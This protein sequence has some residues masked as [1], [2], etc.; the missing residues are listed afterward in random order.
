M[1]CS[2]LTTLPDE[3]A[4]QF[5][6]RTLHNIHIYCAQPLS[7]FSTRVPSHR[8]ILLIVSELPATDLARTY[9]TSKHLSSAASITAAQRMIELGATPARI[10]AF[11]RLAAH[12]ALVAAVGPKPTNRRWSSEWNALA[13]EEFTL[14]GFGSSST[15]T[16]FDESQVLALEAALAQPRA[17]SVRAL[18]WASGWPAEGGAG[19]V[20][21]LGFCGRAALSRALSANDPCYVASTHLI[22]HALQ[23]RAAILAPSMPAPHAYRNLNGTGGLSAD[24]A[25]CWAALPTYEEWEEDSTPRNLHTSAL[26][27]A[28]TAEASFVAN[29]ETAEGYAVLSWAPTAA[30]GAQL[31]HQLQTDSP[32]VCFRSRAPDGKGYHSLIHTGGTSYCVPPMA[33][34]VLESVEKAGAWEAPNGK[35]VNQT[36][37]TVGVTFL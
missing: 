25:N 34:L 35:R 29:E 33:T 24:D 36:L 20:A 27:L 5:T 10:N 16:L 32:V 2:L 12:E 31:T 6:R 3:Y 18:S 23:E 30:G 26:I 21:L 37:Y 9:I 22:A 28:D 15:V 14:R 17:T 8:L 4:H 11:R 1:D 13:A 7:F 19:V